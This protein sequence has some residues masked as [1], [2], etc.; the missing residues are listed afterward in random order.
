MWTDSGAERR[1]NG[2][3]GFS[4]S[5]PKNKEFD[6]LLKYLPWMTDCARHLVSD[7]YAKDIVSLALLDA[8]LPTKPPPPVDDEKRVKA[9]LWT[10]LHF[11][12]RGVWRAK[13]KQKL[14]TPWEEHANASI[15]VKSPDWDATI[16]NRQWLRLALDELT[17]EQRSLVIECDVEGVSLAQLSRT[18]GISEDTL[19]TRLRRAHEQLRAT[20]VG[21]CR[22]RLRAMFP[23]YFVSRDVPEAAEKHESWTQRIRRAFWQ[24]ARQPMPLGTSVLVVACVL[25]LAPGSPCA[26]DEPLQATIAPEPV[27]GVEVVISSQHDAVLPGTAE[28]ESA[29]IAPKPVVKALPEK[30]GKGIAPQNDGSDVEDMLLMQAKAA[31]NRRDVKRALKLLD[32]HERRFPNSK[33]AELRETLRARALRMAKEKP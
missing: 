3:K 9:W 18:S 15:M 12:A 21:L 14:Q 1:V 32:E 17:D 24:I 19:R 5:R 22:N 25:G 27:Q 6:E 2:E 31:I 4:V 20:L 33:N 16:E 8:Y 23:F 10:L 30:H 11:R 26:Q 29:T 13:Q 7:E 28:L